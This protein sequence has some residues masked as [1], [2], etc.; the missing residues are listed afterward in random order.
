MRR[1]IIMVSTTVALLLT[2]PVGTACPAQAA[3][4]GLVGKLACQTNRDGNF[5]I[6]SFD[7]S[8]KEEL[9]PD[10]RMLGVVFETG[11]GAYF[12]RLVGP[13]ATAR[14]LSRR[15]LPMM[16]TAA[17]LAVAAALGGLYL[18]YY[19]SLAAGASVAAVLVGGYLAALA[20]S[21]AAATIRR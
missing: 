13:A 8:A 19:A 7:P 17:A 1:A 14:L 4:P 20:P 12:M 5:E 2:G 16:A 11:K 6:Y 9:R 18:S 21:L 10:S 3:V 15:L